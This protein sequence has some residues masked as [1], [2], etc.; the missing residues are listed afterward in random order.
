MIDFTKNLPRHGTRG[1]LLA[2]RPAHNPSRTDDLLSRLPLGALAYLLLCA[3]IGAALF[4]FFGNQSGLGIL[5][6]WASV[7][8]GLSFVVVAG[9]AAANGNLSTLLNVFVVAA[10]PMMMRF[11][12]EILG[13]ASETRGALPT[14]SAILE[15]AVSMCVQWGV[16]ALVTFMAVMV[17]AGSGNSDADE[18]LPD[19]D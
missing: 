15:G 6:L 4:Y 7:V 14:P 9:A 5:P 1:P 18:E 19:A 16:A 17:L 3:G 11:V 2:H 8:A 12:T 10:L 13:S